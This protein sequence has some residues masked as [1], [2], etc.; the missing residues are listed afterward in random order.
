MDGGQ[1]PPIRGRGAPPAQERNRR[2]RFF[3]VVEAI[4]DIV[5]SE[6]IER[7][8]LPGDT[9]Q[10]VTQG[11]VLF[12]HSRAAV[13]AGTYTL[14]FAVDAANQRLPFSFGLGD[15][16]ARDGGHAFDLARFDTVSTWI[17]V[18]GNDANP[19]D[20]PCAWDRYLATTRVQRAQELVDALR[21]IGADVRLTIFQAPRTG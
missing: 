14:A 3:E 13:S 21:Q 16:P 2:G 15:L 8:E 19:A 18:G 20:L 12:W 9:G 5:G 10:N 4:S 1:P 17:G 6:P 7:S 11:V